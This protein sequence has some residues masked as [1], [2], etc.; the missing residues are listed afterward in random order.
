MILA[1]EGQRQHLLD[2]HGQALACLQHAGCGRSWLLE[3]AVCDALAALQQ[4]TF[5]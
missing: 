3:D 2:Q 4:A 5:R 1:A